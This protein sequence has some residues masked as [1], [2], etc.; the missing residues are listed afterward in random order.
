MPS[1]LYPRV[2]VT[3]VQEQ[4]LYPKTSQGLLRLC[5]PAYPCYFIPTMRFL[6]KPPFSVTA[7]FSALLS[8]GLLSGVAYAQ[9]TLEYRQFVPKLAV[10]PPPAL[11]A[12]P[13][14]SLSSTSVSFGSTA[15]HTSSTRQVVLTNQ[16]GRAL[17]FGAAPSV[18]GASA[19]SAGATSCGQ[20]LEAGASCSSEVVF[21]PTSEGVFEGNL[22]F[23]SNTAGS[24][25]QVSLSG[26]GA[27]PV[28]LLA[29]SLPAAVQGLSF[30]YDF[31][32]LL[33]VANEPSVAHSLASWTLVGAL[34]AGLS[35]N[36]STAV[37]SGVPTETVANVQLHLSVTYRAN[38]TQ[39]A[40]RLTVVPP[41]G[42]ALTGGHRA[43][44]D[45]SL[46]A[47]CNDYRHPRVGYVYSGAADSG[48]Y[49][50]QPAGQAALDVWCD[51]TTDGG[52]WTLIVRAQ[53][54]SNAHAN[55]AAVG[56]LTSPSQAT[57]AKL[58][59]AVINAIPKTMYRMRN[60]GGT[61]SVYFDTSDVFSATR[62]VA[63]RA[64]VT[65]ENPVWRGPFYDPHHRGLNTWQQG[66]GAFAGAATITGVYTGSSS[67][68]GCRLG[69]GITG[70]TAGWCGAGDSGTV[71]LK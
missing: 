62:Q 4:W 24:P 37:L 32:P 16:G 58:S 25:H 68:D 45:G 69:I 48:I 28:S 30:Q 43:W 56:A 13:G 29:A 20:T 39:Q 67:G 36:P 65:W 35:F 42:L 41:V 9:T 40:Y 33:A 44:A 49:R 55:A 2:R 47:S 6:F 27:N 14:V 21:S 38:S 71:W 26:T 57:A 46:A 22:V 54:G 34:P 66:A 52:G 53:A 11:V 15:L 17:L 70:G 5:P 59:D 60:S 64:S 18:Y 19:F 3:R 23:V 50:I 63:N 10:A 51:M 12:P 8:C 31:K 61:T 1:P 7:F